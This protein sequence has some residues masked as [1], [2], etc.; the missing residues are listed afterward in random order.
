MPLGLAMAKSRGGM[1]DKLGT[2]YVVIIRAVP[3]II[4][5]FIIQIFFSRWFKLPLL[6]I[7]ISRSWILPTVSM[8]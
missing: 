2:V 8:S 7:W 3:S 1:A 4:I 6:F 5:H